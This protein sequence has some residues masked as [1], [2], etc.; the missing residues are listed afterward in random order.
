MKKVIS[1]FS[2]ILLALSILTVSISG[3]IAVPVSAAENDDS[4]KK[5]R[6]GYYD[7]RNCM[8][9]AQDG[10]RKYGYVHDVLGEVSAVCKFM[11]HCK[12]VRLMFSA[13]TIIIMI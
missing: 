11:K 4:L 9:G 13:N 7:L 5:V 8:E 10:A 12:K 2:S 3:I 1:L 6:V